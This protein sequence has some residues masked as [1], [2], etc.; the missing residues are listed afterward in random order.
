MVSLPLLAVVILAASCGSTTTTTTSP[1]DTGGVVIFVGDSPQCDILSYR[2]VVS[3]ITL[4]SQEGYTPQVFTDVSGAYIRVD[5]AALQDVTSILHSG[6]IRVGTYNQA[7][8]A[9]G[10][11]QFAVFDPTKS[12]PS[13][14]IFPRFTSTSK[15]FNIKPPLTVVKGGVY[16]L[17]MDLDVRHSIGVDEQGNVNGDAPPAIALVTL[18]PNGPEGFGRLQ[19]MKGFVLSVTNG[20]NVSEFIGTLNVQIHSGLSD[21]PVV[22]VNITPDTLINGSLATAPVVAAVLGGSFVEIDGF[23]DSHGNLVANSVEVE[24]QENVS[25]RRIALIGY[26]TSITRDVTGN[27]SQFELYVRDEQP[28]SPSV[29]P[30]D[31]FV[32]VDVSPTTSF[33]NPSRST[34]FSSLPFDATSLQ[35]GEQVIVHGPASSGSGGVAAVEANSIY[36]SLQT[37]EGNFSSLIQVGSDDKTGAFWLKTCAQMF[38]GL[39]MLV[40]TNSDT[41]FVNITGLSGLAPQPTL[42]IKGL[43]FYEPQG[44][45]LEGVTVPPGTLVMLADQVHQV[46]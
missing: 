28:E 29:V 26:I 20:S 10:P 45:T 21:V 34:F 1:T 15:T 40:L 9:F 24:D 32:Q 18:T 27:V 39:P 37:H 35:I 4:I 41:A 43:L 31:T 22:P 38:Q 23:V 6:P 7:T 2:T 17:R 19:D 14:L 3:G 25:T 12:P 8:I 36:Q 44:T 11:A 16:G 5:F 46:P 30:L 42:I 13:Q 33:H